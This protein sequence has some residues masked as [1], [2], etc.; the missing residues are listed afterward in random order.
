MQEVTRGI[1]YRDGA[2]RV[3]LNCCVGAEIDRASP[4]RMDGSCRSSFRFPRDSRVLI[5][6]E[7]RV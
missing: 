3:A 7:F 4:F 5:A 6:E 1:A 2:R